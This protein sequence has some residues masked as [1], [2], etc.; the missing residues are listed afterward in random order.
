MF[1]P[2]PKGKI[3]VN[4]GPACLEPMRRP[5]RPKRVFSECDVDYVNKLFNCPQKRKVPPVCTPNENMMGPPRLL[6]TTESTTTTTTTTTIETT[7]QQSTTEASNEIPMVERE[8]EAA[9]NENQEIETTTLEVSEAE[10]EETTV[11]WSPATEEIA[12]TTTEQPA[13][14]ESEKT[15]EGEPE[16]EDAT[17]NS[18]NGNELVEAES[19]G[20]S[21]TGSVVLPMVIPPNMHQ[22]TQEPDITTVMPSLQETTE[23]EEEE[24]EITT[25]TTPEPTEASTETTETP[26]KSTTDTT[27]PPP[28]TMFIS[29]ITSTPMTTMEVQ[30][31]EWVK[32]VEE[33]FRNR[34][35]DESSST[36]EKPEKPQP[37]I[38]P[39]EDK[40]GSVKLLKVK[41]TETNEDN[42]PAV[43]EKG[44]SN[45]KLTE[46]SSESEER[47]SVDLPGGSISVSK[48]KISTMIERTKYVY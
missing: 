39:S 4:A 41:S 21:M 8:E 9:A 6:A 15:D 31:A 24:E 29:L 45:E 38:K 47:K 23:F 40:V 27:P 43:V 16:D 26:S 30:P 18:N 20:S 28:T 46:K 17:S 25:T 35:P 44:K 12:L 14:P 36:E 2:F 13:E 10:P 3:Q 22:T 1:H 37:E 48:T 11:E 34:M 5:H 33:S 7:E 42:K 19:S 32:S